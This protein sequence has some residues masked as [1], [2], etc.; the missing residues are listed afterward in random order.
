MQAA[1]LTPEMQQAYNKLMYE[2]TLRDEFVTQ[3]QPDTSSITARDD[4]LNSVQRAMAAGASN[5]TM[6]SET[7]GAGTDYD[8]PVQDSGK[9]TPDNYIEGY[10]MTQETVTNTDSTNSPS[11][12]SSDV[13]ASI[14]V[15]GAVGAIYLGFWKRRKF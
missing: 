15:V 8:T 1:G 10:E 5:Q 2:A 3:Q 6:I 11:F 14:F 4:S 7:G 12:S 13:F 9:S